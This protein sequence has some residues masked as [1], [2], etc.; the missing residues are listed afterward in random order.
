[1]EEERIVGTITFLAEDGTII[2]S[3][4]YEYG[5]NIMQ[6]EA[7][8]KAAD[9][10]YTYTFAGWG[11]NFSETC[12]G[13]A[14][15]TATYTATY[16]DYTVSFLDWN[17]TVIL[18]KT[19]HYGD[20]VI[21]PA[22]PVRAGESYLSYDFTGWDKEVTATCAG[23]A[24]YTATYQE[25]V[26]L[27]TYLQEAAKEGDTVKL[28]KDTQ[29]D[30]LTLGGGATLDLNGY[31]LTADYFTSYGTVVDGTDGGDALVIVNKG[32]HVAGDNS[33]M[34]IYDTAAGGY[35]FY[36][37]QL[38]NLGYKTVTGDA[39]ALKIGFRLTLSNTDGYRVLGATTDAKLDLLTYVSWTGAL[40][41]FRYAFTDAT[42]QNYAALVR[43]DIEAKG[44]SSKAITLG[45]SG[46]DSLG[47]GAEV[48]VQPSVESVPGVTA[49][50]ETRIWNVQ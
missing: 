43:A 3:E 39:G 9:K 35:R 32:I 27:Q 1:M 17:G 4:K 18:E 19:Y 40:G 5:Q 50:G 25:N 11:A 49:M 10:I 30:Y 31:T 42:L 45:I 13:D 46:V 23:N 15:Y 34:P 26:E 21:V 6:P 14:T 8:A 7:P 48:S 16:I 29:V 41:T 12:A 38:Q 47:Q 24:T 22:D 36:K 44:S 20:T 33:F 37:Y 28:V 2:L